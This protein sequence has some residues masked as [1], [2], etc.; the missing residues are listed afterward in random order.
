[1][2]YADGFSKR[3]R[4]APPKAAVLPTHIPWTSLNSLS[5]TAELR[6]N[7]KLRIDEC[8]EQLRNKRGQTARLAMS[9]TIYKHKNV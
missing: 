2:A 5:I 1:M 6:N 9:E 7:K 4:R 8:K 3:T